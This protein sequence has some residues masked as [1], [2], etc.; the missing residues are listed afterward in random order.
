MMTP[1]EHNERGQEMSVESYDVPFQC[2]YT[3]FPLPLTPVFRTAIPD[4]LDFIKG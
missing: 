1:Q 4:A 2:H 3:Q